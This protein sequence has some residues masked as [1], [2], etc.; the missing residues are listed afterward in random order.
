MIILSSG[1]WTLYRRFFEE[2]QETRLI[3]FIEF[4]EFIGFIDGLMKKTQ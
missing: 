1:K 3:G 2:G 4:I